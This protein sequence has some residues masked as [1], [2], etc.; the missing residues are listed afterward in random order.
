MSSKKKI[1][2]HGP[3]A[4]IAFDK[5]LSKCFTSFPILHINEETTIDTI[6]DFSSWLL[7]PSFS[8]NSW[9]GFGPVDQ[10]K[11]SYFDAMLKGI[12]ESLHH[13]VSW[14]NSIAS[15]SETYQSRVQNIWCYDPAIKPTKKVEDNIISEL[16]QSHIYEVISIFNRD[17]TSEDLMKELAIDFIEYKENHK[18]NCLWESLRS[19]D[20]YDLVSEGLKKKLILKCLL[21]YLESTKTGKK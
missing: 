5:H 18:H 17:L 2:F 9:V 3:N 10:M 11:S 1:L 6:R 16:L 4:K 8:S 15:V 19:I 13:I 14:C 21:E 20:K 12:E 7:V